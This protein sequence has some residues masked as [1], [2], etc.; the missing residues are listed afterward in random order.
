MKEVTQRVVARDQRQR[1]SRGNEIPDKEFSPCE[2]SDAD[3]RE[4][5][6]K[7]YHRGLEEN[8]GEDY[9]EHDGRLFHRRVNRA[10]DRESIR[11]TQR[12]VD[13]GKTSYPTQEVKGVKRLILEI[14]KSSYPQPCRHA[15][16]QPEPKTLSRGAMVPW[17][18]T[19]RGV[20]SGNYVNALH[21]IM[22][23]GEAL[24]LTMAPSYY[25]IGDAYH[26]AGIASCMSAVTG[27]AG[28][29]GSARSRE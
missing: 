29:R 7:H 25:R 24:T 13:E 6:R 16:Y 17:R 14:I 23:N 3:V 21:V 15:N 18:A 5:R 26:R 9:S 28:S 11:E 2:F 22:I 27:H 12:K 20:M 8:R 4:H 19:G 1:H 10:Y